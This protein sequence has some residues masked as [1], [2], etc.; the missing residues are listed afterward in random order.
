MCDETTMPEAEV[1]GDPVDGNPIWQA[2]FADLLGLTGWTRPDL[3]KRLDVTRS[4]VSDWALGYR[5]MPGPVR[6]Y[7][8]LVCRI[9]ALADDMGGG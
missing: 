5:R 2:E 6:A 7:M 1:I 9:K 3:A 4:T 8:R